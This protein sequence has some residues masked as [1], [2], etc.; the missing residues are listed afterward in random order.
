MLK[1]ALLKLGQV[2]APSCPSAASQRALR[3]PNTPRAVAHGSGAHNDLGFL[4]VTPFA[5]ASHRATNP[6]MNIGLYVANPRMKIG[7][8]GSFPK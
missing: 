6:I 8:Y 1:R 5:S 2:A 4:A 3:F 7:Q